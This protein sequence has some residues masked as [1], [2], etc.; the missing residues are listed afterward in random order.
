MNTSHNH[1]PGPWKW[2]GSRQSP[3]DRIYLSTPNG[4]A[5]W[6]NLRNAEET[7]NA[8]LIAAAPELLAA[9]EYLLPYVEELEYPTGS[10]AAKQA[11]AAIAKAK[12][13][14]S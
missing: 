4:Y 5:N 1:T 13:A 6:T 14:Q 10:D 7:A 8:H 2:I 9:L 11:R 12:G 3:Q